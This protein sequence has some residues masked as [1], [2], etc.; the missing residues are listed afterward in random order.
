LTK[1]IY[2]I[3]P[4]LKLAMEKKFIPVTN[5]REYSYNVHDPILTHTVKIKYPQ[6]I[7]DDSSKIIIPKG[8]SP[9]TSYDASYVNEPIQRKNDIPHQTPLP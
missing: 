1:G 9:G 2:T 8:P 6:N 5:R 7:T 3:I 4:V